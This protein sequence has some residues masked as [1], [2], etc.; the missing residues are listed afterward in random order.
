MIDNPGIPR[1]VIEFLRENSPQFQFYRYIQKRQKALAESILDYTELSNLDKLIA[2]SSFVTRALIAVKYK[3]LDASLL[4]DLN[5]TE[6]AEAVS[7]A[8]SLNNYTKVNEVLKKHSDSLRLFYK[9]SR[10]TP[11]K[12][13]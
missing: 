6:V 11:S 13:E 5:I 10:K 1:G 7:S 9:N 2:C 3:E 4:D 8:V 12:S